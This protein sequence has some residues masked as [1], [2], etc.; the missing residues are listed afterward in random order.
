VYDDSALRY[1]IDYSK[2]PEVALFPELAAWVDE[3]LR[4]AGL[5]SAS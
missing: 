2:A 3:Y 1:F 5:R 4:A